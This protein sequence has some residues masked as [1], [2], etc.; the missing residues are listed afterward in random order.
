MLNSKTS[1]GSRLYASKQQQHMLG[2]KRNF[3]EAGRAK[4]VNLLYLVMRPL[5]GIF[6][7]NK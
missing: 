2:G 1:A 7:I 3:A 6:C 4:L 5:P